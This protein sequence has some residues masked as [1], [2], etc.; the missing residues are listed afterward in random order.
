MPNCFQLFHKGSQSAAVL[1]DVDSA[2]CQHFNV[3]CDDVHWHH[4]WYD[5]IGFYLAI[6]K[7]WNEIRDYLVRMIAE[8]D[9]DSLKADWQ[10]MEKIR[11]FLE[12]NYTVK[13]WYERK[14]FATN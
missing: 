9:S 4:D 3:P 7:S 1:Q 6:G 11:E 8:S 5:C 2:I 10:H 13:A 12:A 14:G